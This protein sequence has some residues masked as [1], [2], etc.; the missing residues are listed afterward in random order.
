ML[1]ST[2]SLNISMMKNN[3]RLQLNIK[4]YVVETRFQQRIF[5]LIDKSFS[6]DMA[7]IR[8]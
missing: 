4:K 3:N 7:H 2:I 8:M 6:P 1:M 5:K